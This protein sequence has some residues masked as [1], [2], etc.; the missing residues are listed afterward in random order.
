MCG[1]TALVIDLR[2]WSVPGVCKQK[3]HSRTFLPRACAT[4]RETSEFSRI[5]SFL[6]VRSV[7]QFLCVCMNVLLVVV[8]L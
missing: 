5:E 4:G 8:V 3:P 1:L 7:L 6:F 2:W